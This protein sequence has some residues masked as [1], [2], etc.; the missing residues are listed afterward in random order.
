[1]EA[2]VPTCIELYVACIWREETASQMLHGLCLPASIVVQK[3]WCH[4]DPCLEGED[5]RVLP[6]YSGWSCSSG[7]KV[8]TTKASIDRTRLYFTASASCNLPPSF[9]PAAKREGYVM[10]VKHCPRHAPL[11]LGPCEKPVSQHQPPFQIYGVMTGGGIPY[12]K[13][14]S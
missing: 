10:L 3:W 9:H 12:L 5:C 1:M 2:S 8:K 7:N 4:M 13:Q 11:R 6:D 14:G